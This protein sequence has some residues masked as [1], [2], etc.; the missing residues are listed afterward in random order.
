MIK[1]PLCGKIVTMKTTLAIYFREKNYQ[2][3]YLSAGKPEMVSIPEPDIENFIKEKK[4]GRVLLLI[5]K[6]GVV[7]RRLQFPFSQKQKINLVLKAELEDIL[8]RPAED[9]C[10]YWYFVKRQRKHSE[11]VLCGLNRTFYEFWTR[12][13]KTYHFRLSISVDSLVLFSIF[14]GNLKQPDYFCLWIEEQYL[15]LNQ[16]EKGVLVNSYSYTFRGSEEYASFV[17]LLNTVVS[18]KN[19]PI[20]WSGKK[21]VFSNF[22]LNGTQLTWPVAVEKIPEPYFLPLSW[23]VRPNA[24]KG[25]KFRNLKKPGTISQPDVLL[26]AGCLALILFFLSP[27]FQIPNANHR[28]EELKINMEQ[29]FREACPEVTRVVDPVTQMRERMRGNNLPGANFP[30]RISILK[31]L[32]DFVQ[33]VPPDLRIE[34]THFMVTGNLLF[35]SGVVEDLK[36]VEKLRVSLENSGK[37]SSAK[38]GDLAF[39]NQQRVVFSL[40]LEIP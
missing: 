26:A 5:A 21:E 30:E 24:I 1:S 36:S 37:F 2:A 35:V 23:L 38:V 28:V 11:I 7:L 3:V 19:Q 13:Q 33:S 29:I 40:N 12:I 27:Y 18:E 14:S 34:V 20:Y 6:P 25:L 9:F 8:A 39:D 31:A 15:L 17:P 4:P 10:Y 16:V 22:G 32:A